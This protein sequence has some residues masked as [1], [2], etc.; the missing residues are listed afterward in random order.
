MFLVNE[1]TKPYLD[2]SAVC[3]VVGFEITVDLSENPDA[4]WE[5]F[6]MKDYPACSD[7]SRTL[8][9]HYLYA[10]LPYNSK[11]CGIDTSV[12]LFT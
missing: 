9:N 5:D 10:K 7:L 12:C 3:S 4:V 2:M 8:K 1:F 6:Y 11:F